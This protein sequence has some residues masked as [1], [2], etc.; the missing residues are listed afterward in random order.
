MTAPGVGASPRLLEPPLHMD[1]RDLNKGDLERGL[2][3]HQLRSVVSVLANLALELALAYPASEP[4]LAAC[5]TGER[6]P[7]RY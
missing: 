2:N 5:E 4:S 7:F 3:G 1:T 6:W